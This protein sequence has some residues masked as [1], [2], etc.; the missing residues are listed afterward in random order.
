MSR[1]R[2]LAAGIFLFAALNIIDAQRLPLL[3]PLKPLALVA[4]NVVNVR[5]GTVHANTTV[6]IRNGRIESLGVSSLPGGVEVIDLKGKYIIP[7]LIDAH[8][9]VSDL[10]AARR[11]LDAGV[12]TL[13]SAGVSRYA[14]VGLRDLS[15]EAAM[16]I[17]QVLAAGYALAPELPSDAFLSDPEYWELESGLNTIEKIRRAQ[18]SSSL[19]AAGRQTKIRAR[20]GVLPG[21]VMLYGPTI[22]TPERC[23]T[24]V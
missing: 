8:A 21:P 20:L 3:P 22:S 16:A 17:P 9:H 23:G 2:V 1:V 7:G 12:T 10:A 5:D 6:I 13:R 11:A 15:R 18:P 4:A 24:V 14:D 19:A